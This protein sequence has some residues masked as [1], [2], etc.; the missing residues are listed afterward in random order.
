MSETKLR[1]Y[2]KRATAS[3]HETREELKE[4]KD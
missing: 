2:L 3:L 4:L 1:D